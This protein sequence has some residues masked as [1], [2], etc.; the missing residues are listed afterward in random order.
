VQGR[1]DGTALCTAASFQTGIH[2]R[3]WFPLRGAGILSTRMIRQIAGQSN[4]FMI[5]LPLGWTVRIEILAAN[6]FLF[7]TMEPC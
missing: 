5:V 6:H 7:M 2:Q 1:H 4:R 3:S